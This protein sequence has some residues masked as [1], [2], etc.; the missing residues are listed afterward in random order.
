M[1]SFICR[2]KPGI[3]LLTLPL[4]EDGIEH[5]EEIVLMTTKGEAICLGI[6]LM[7]RSPLYT[8]NPCTRSKLTFS[9]LPSK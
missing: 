1:V 5:H 4:T 2:S 3:S 7:V 9:S 8:A 6:A